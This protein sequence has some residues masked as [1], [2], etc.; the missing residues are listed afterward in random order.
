MSLHI[1]THGRGAPLVLVHGWALHG[2]V[3]APLVE[4]LADR[5]ELH[6]VDL[7]GHGRSRD[8]TVPL[9]LAATVAAICAATPPAAWLGWSLGGLFALKAAASS[10]QVRA[11]AMVSSVPRFTA[12]PDWPHAVPPAVFAQFGRDLAQDYRGTLERFIALDTLGSAQGHVT[13]RALRAMLF[14]RGEPAPAALQAGLALLERS[15][16]RHLL[17]GLGMPSLWI[18]G[19]RDRLVQPRGM[20]AAAGLAPQAGFVE[21]AGG[22]HAPFLAHLDAVETALVPFLDGAVRAR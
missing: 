13:L 4:R 22:G 6:V 11:L 3:F 19:A 10:G 21:I 14:A 15:D 9:T 8:S 17:P 1:E 5:F 7:P 2:G 20:A 16:L 12:A 18:V